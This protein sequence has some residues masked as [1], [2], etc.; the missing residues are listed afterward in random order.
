MIQT[1]NKNKTSYKSGL[2]A[3]SKTVGDTT[4]DLTFTKNISADVEVQRQLGSSGSNWTALS[5][6]A[7]TL[8]EDSG[9]NPEATYRYRTRVKGFV[10]WIYT[11]IT[12]LASAGTTS[13]GSGSSTLTVQNK[14]Y[15]HVTL[16]WTNDQSWDSVWI[17]QRKVTAGS[18]SSPTYAGSLGWANYKILGLNIGRYVDL[19]DLSPN[20]GYDYRVAAVTNL[21]EYARNGTTPTLSAWQEVAVT[22]D[23]LPT[24]IDTVYDITDSAY[25]NSDT[26][27]ALNDAITAAR[28]AG[29]GIINIPAGSY[30]VIMPALDVQEQSGGQLFV[31][32]TGSYKSSF[33]S[34]DM[35][36]IVIRGEVD[37]N[38]DPATFLTLYLPN[39]QAMSN[40]IEVLQPGQTDPG[41]HSSTYVANVV[42]G[43]FIVLG[44][45]TENFTLKDIDIDGNALPVNTGKEWYSLD[46]KRYQWDITHKCVTHWT[47]ARNVIIDNVKTRSWRGE[48]FYCGGNQTEK[49]LIKNCEIRRSNSSSLSGSYDLECYNTFIYDSSNAAVES[50]IFDGL[51]SY[52]TGQSFLQHHLIYNCQFK[53]LDQSTEG[54]MKGLSGSKNFAGIHIFNYGPTSCQTV[55]RTDVIDYGAAGYGPWYS[56]E[57]ALFYD[58][59]LQYPASAQIYGTNA[60][61]TDTKVQ[62]SYDIFDGRMH[63]CLWLD[64]RLHY[65]KNE[66]NGHN[67]MYSQAQT[68]GE[69]DDW[70]IDVIHVVND[71]GGS[72][73]INRL[74]TDTTST[75]TG[76]ENFI[77]KDWTID[78]GL[79]FKSDGFITN[80]GNKNNKIYPGFENCPFPYRLTY[81]TMGV[82]PNVSFYAEYTDSRVVLYN[83]PSG[84]NWVVTDIPNLD[85]YVVGTTFKFKLDSYNT[86]KGDTIKF[87]VDTTWNTFS[88]D[89]TITTSS[90][91]L[92]CTL[93]TA[94][95][96]DFVSLA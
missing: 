88:T 51:T 31:T 93:N 34:G 92:T 63:K 37:T 90:Q 62:S 7:G 30:D 38:G 28:A 81:L 57:N 89:K 16:T 8:L 23:A 11:I 39:G 36:N 20:T 43:Y 94:K 80:T 60:F 87:P 19:D 59:T 18:W 1:Q 91:V 79:T 6:V 21:R 45:G 73:Q 52:F 47:A 32:S 64:L 46:E 70:I 27:T 84:T 24:G 10:K 12:T 74:W 75:S 67:L 95:M 35:S 82:S 14:G 25:A 42:R 54:Y 2:S 44:N 69:Q 65:D 68:A 96:L 55:V 26:F 5:D 66:D 77:W 50:A 3:I 22:T 17:I 13:G 71:S 29:G 83:Q 86:G 15:Q 76:R 56:C 4:C 61:Y 72:I 41:D 48:V 49:Y 58:S 85:R 9:L 78:A 40:W 33:F 53:C